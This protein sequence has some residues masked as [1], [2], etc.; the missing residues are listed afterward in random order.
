MYSYADRIRA[1]GLYIKLGKRVKP[2]IRQLGYPTKEIDDARQ[3]LV[4]ERKSLAALERQRTTEKTKYTDELNE[5]NKAQ[6]RT[7]ASAS[8]TRRF[9]SPCYATLAEQV[10]RAERTVQVMQESEIHATRQI[11]GLQQQLRETSEQLKTVT[12]RLSARPVKAK[13][14]PLRHP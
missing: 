13:L 2:T 4:T 12:A 3:A 14:P 9:E 11:E 10:A 7:G 6:R 1:V 5:A 8:S